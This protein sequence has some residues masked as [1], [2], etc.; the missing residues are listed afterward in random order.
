MAHHLRQISIAFGAILVSLLLGRNYCATP[1]PAELSPF[2]TSTDSICAVL[3]ALRRINLEH[4]KNAPTPFGLL[5]LD[6][7]AEPFSPAQNVAHLGARLHA[8]VQKA[9]L[10][11]W[12]RLQASVWS[13]VLRG[14]ASAVRVYD[15]SVRVGFVLLD[16]VRRVEEWRAG[17]M[18][19]FGHI[20]HLDAGRFG[21]VLA[22]DTLLDHGAFVTDK[23]S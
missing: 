2:E 5:G 18:G 3:L 6:P 11:A 8:A 23:V 22:S 17:A 7:S 12:H 9:V 4:P 16:D 14:D 20:I 21:S 1:E 19:W 13:G 15:A 10:T